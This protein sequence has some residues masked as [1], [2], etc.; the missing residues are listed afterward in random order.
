MDGEPEA[1]VDESLRSISI[2]PRER[3]ARIETLLVAIEGKLDSKANKSDIIQLEARIWAIEVNG[4]HTA[5]EAI[6]KYEAISAKREIDIK[7][8]QDELEILRSDHHS[9]K[10][11]IAWIGGALAVAAVVGEYFM[12]HLL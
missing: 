6:S 2:S 4:S 1:Y 12:M 7:T 9:L 11:R 5:T 8:I 10:N 3:L